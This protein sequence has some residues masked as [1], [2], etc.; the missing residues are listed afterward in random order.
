MAQASEPPQMIWTKLLTGESFVPEAR[1]SH[2]AVGLRGP[3]GSTDM[4][5][6][7]GVIGGSR[8]NSIVRFCHGSD[9]LRC[10]LRLCCQILTLFRAGTNAWDALDCF[11][12]APSPRSSE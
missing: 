1:H 6:F 11:G 9:I 12:D 3:T 4:V 5:V 2:V 8:T 10:C 7:G